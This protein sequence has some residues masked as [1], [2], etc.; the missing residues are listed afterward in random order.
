MLGM[1]F[2]DGQGL[3]NQMFCLASVKSLALDNGYVFGT[4]NQK[5][6]A[7]NIHNKKGIYFMDVDLGE[8]IDDMATFKKYY[9]KE[10]RIWIKNSLHDVIHGCYIAGVDS[11]LFR[12]K[13]NTIVY[14]NLQSERYFKKYRDD[15]KKWFRVKK[16]YESY[17]Y[18][19]DD[20]C[21]MNMR[22]GE[23]VGAKELYL[24]KQYWLNAMEY[25]KKI[26]SNMRFMIVTEDVKHAKRM[27]PDLPVFH[28]DIGGDYVTV[29][30]ARYLIASNSSFAC[31]PA[32]TSE[33]CKFVLAPKYWARYNVSSGYW[34]SEQNIYSGWMYM[35]REGKVFTAEECRKELENYKKSDAYRVLKA[36]KKPEGM[37]YFVQSGLLK[38]K[39]YLPVW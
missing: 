15:L 33:T 39:G 27:F 25:M 35:D 32:F 22:G 31:F 1:E 18:S 5:M 9:E 4:A 12:I 37:K 7:Q 11:N 23:Y 21:I 36:A 6:F 34:A 16:E 20:L 30:N 14:G 13:D 24:K 17:E 28:F 3:G 10:E 8:N 29:K 2:L 38:L 19:Q 26:N